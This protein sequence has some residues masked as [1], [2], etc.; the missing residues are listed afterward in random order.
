MKVKENSV[1]NNTPYLNGFRMALARSTASTRY[2]ML[3][4]MRVNVLNPPRTLHVYSLA[5]SFCRRRSA[6][7]A[8]T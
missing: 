1:F 3:E 4:A 6:A 2:H 7:M 5:G 8:T